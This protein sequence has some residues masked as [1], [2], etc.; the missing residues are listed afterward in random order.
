MSIYLYIFL[1]LFYSEGSCLGWLGYDWTIWLS[2]GRFWRTGQSPEPQ[3]TPK[4]GPGIF[5]WSIIHA[6][7]A[8][9]A[10]A[11]QG[12]ELQSCAGFSY[13]AG[14][15]WWQNTERFFCSWKCSPEQ[16]NNV[17]FTFA[18]FVL[19]TNWFPAR[20]P[21]KIFSYSFLKVF[22]GDP[23]VLW[24]YCSQRATESQMIHRSIL[25]VCFILWESKSLHLEN[26]LF[27]NWK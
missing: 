19:V 27:W 21:G 4:T 15:G 1:D 25:V 5:L 2:S 9:L 3:C 7:R 24:I 13:T 14:G 17:A 23:R 16:Q 20:Y 26:V 12:S 10:G 6:A 8:E 18:A 22:S 11:R